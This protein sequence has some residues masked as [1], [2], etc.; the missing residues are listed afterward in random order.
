MQMNIPDWKQCLAAILCA[1]LLAA[2]EP[3]GAQS[4]GNKPM[5][6]VASPELAGPYRQTTLVAV[7]VDGRYF[8]F[9]LNRATE[10]KLSALFPAH[11]PSALVASPVYFGG[12]EMNDALFAVV[13]RNP[14]ENALQLFGGLFVTNRAAAIDRIIEQTPNEA[15][16]FAGFVGWAA[17]ELEAEI[18]SGHWYVTEP[19][20][21]LVF[22]NDTKGMWEELV[23]RLGN[24]HAPAR[25]GLIQTRVDAGAPA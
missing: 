4:A 19:E 11:A 16:Y 10:I 6:L 15:R 21:A 14:G 2:C 1:G 22:R 20:A 17:G 12:P 18:A 7:P 5:L 9:I 23:K 25:R 8:G 13:P 3:V 24:G